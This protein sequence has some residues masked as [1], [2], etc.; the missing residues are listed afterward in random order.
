[1]TLTSD[2]RFVRLAYQDA[3]ALQK[4]YER[5]QDYMVLVTGAGPAPDEAQH[6]LQALPPGIAIEQKLV[7]GLRAQSDELL[8]AVD[9]IKNF[10]REGTWYI[11][12]FI[13]SPK[14]RR[15]GLGRALFRAVEKRAVAAGASHIDLAA[16]DSNVDA[17]GFWARM[18]FGEIGR[19]QY[20]VKD[21][22]STFVLMQLVLPAQ[23]A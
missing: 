14:V 12:E 10:P 2:D 3:P 23:R 7:L 17:L 19:K 21:V 9:V 11:G 4:L 20:R 8:G 22:E 18:G 13:L 16:H 15:S 1:V 6:L 5:C